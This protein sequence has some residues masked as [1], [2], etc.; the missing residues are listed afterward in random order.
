VRYDKSIKNINGVLKKYSLDFLENGVTWKRVS[1]ETTESRYELYEDTIYIHPE[2]VGWSWAFWPTTMSI[3]FHE[4]GHRY[5]EK[6]LNRNILKRKDIK[7]LFGYYHKRY[8]RNLKRASMASKRDM[9]DFASRYSLVHPADD[10]AEIFT[11]CLVYIT[12]D[13]NPEDFPRDNMKSEICGKKIKKMLELLDF[14]RQQ[15]KEKQ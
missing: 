6:F 1:G 2:D 15:Q 5:A 13:R 10:V 4:L 3:M 12:K 11:V 8:H 7:E 14:S 9:F